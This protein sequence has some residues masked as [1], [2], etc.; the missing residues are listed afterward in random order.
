LL[1]NVGPQ[2]TLRLNTA[3]TSRVYQRGQNA[4]ENNSWNFA[5]KSYTETFSQFVQRST[6][7]T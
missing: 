7:F 5:L 4:C 2:K 1:Q 3:Q 6:H